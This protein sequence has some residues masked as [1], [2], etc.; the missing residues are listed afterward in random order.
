MHG[1]TMKI[2][3]LLFKFVVP[4]YE[5]SWRYFLKNGKFNTHATRT[6]NLTYSFCYRDK[7]LNLILHQLM[8]FE[9]L[10]VFRRS[11]LSNISRLHV[12]YASKFQTPYSV[13]DIVF[14]FY[15][16]HAPILYFNTCI[17]F[18]YMFREILCLSSGGQLH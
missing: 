12:P 5:N 7:T 17:T 2:E 18:L 13:Q 4:I 15:Q 6:L 14:S 1:E 8:L 9:E 10:R 3:K 16:L 11:F